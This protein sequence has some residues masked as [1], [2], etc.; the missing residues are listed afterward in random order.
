MSKQRVKGTKFE[1]KLL[2]PLR[3]LWPRMA[4]TGSASQADSDFTDPD[5]ECPYAIEAKHQERIR[6]PEFMD[7]AIASAKRTGQVP[8]LIVQRKN[9]SVNDAYVVMR[10]QDFVEER[11]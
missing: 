1:T 8:L 9:K 10:L 2:S 7:Q 11:Q 6:L 5:G 3:L 4:R